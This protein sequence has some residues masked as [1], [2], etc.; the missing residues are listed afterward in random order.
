MYSSLRANDAIPSLI[1]NYTRC[2]VII[3]KGIVQIYVFYRLQA[4]MHVY[5]VM[6]ESALQWFSESKP[7]WAKENRED[8]G[9]S[10]RAGKMS[11]TLPELIDQ[12]LHNPI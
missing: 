3:S 4:F 11:P 5:N 1:I 7:K 6:V 9:K 2:L 8:E 12:R 10:G